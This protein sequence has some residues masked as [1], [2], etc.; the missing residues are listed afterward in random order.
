MLWFWSLVH[1]RSQCTQWSHAFQSSVFSRSANKQKQK[2]EHLAN[3]P[4]V[5][6]PLHKEH[7]GDLIT[8]GRNMNSGAVQN[9]FVLTIFWNF[10]QYP[11]TPCSLKLIS[12]AYQPWYSV[13]LSQQNSISRLISHR[14]HQSNRTYRLRV[15]AHTMVLK[16]LTQINVPKWLAGWN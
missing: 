7:P 3:Q 13:F 15:S 14:N 10:T 9:N 4:M 5:S 6:T 8:C 2:C 12:T 11:C 1:Y 16:H